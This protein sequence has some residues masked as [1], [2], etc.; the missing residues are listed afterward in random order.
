MARL[1]EPKLDL[2]M[3]PPQGDPMHLAALKEE[4][5]AGR[6]RYIGVQVISDHVY[7]AARGG[8]AQR[9][10]RLH[11][12]RLRHRQSRR[13]EDTILP[14]A[15][16]RKIGVMA[17]FPFGN[18]GGLSCGSGRNLFARVGTRPPARVG[19]EFDAK[20]LGAVLPQVRHQPTRPS[21]WPGVGTTKATHMLD[22]I[23]GGIG[24]LPDEATRTRMA[25]SSTHS[26]GHGAARASAPGA[27][28]TL[29]GHAGPLRG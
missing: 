15:Q 4:K 26:P 8:D 24:R 27:G 18:N 23:G 13:V 25:A 22:N 7:P 14:L 12:R 6:V 28:R 2:V 5:K 10:D 19:R 11:R 29:R 17:F 3:L 9:A 21:P 16:E 20:T 1:K